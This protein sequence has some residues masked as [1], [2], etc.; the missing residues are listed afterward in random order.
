MVSLKKSICVFYKNFSKKERKRIKLNKIKVLEY[1]IEGKRVRDKSKQLT[2][3]DKSW[4]KLLNWNGLQLKS[5]TFAN[6][7]K[8]IRQ[9]DV[10]RKFVSEVSSSYE[11]ANKLKKTT[12]SDKICQ[13]TKQREAVK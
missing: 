13:L 4:I 12:S 5:L 10:L 1:G 9:F 11:S 8:A 2:R 7:W 3:K 6:C